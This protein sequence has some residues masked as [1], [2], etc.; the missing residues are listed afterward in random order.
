MID[1]YTQHTNADWTYYPERE[2]SMY[3]RNV[4]CQLPLYK[5]PNSESHST[6]LTYISYDRRTEGHKLILKCKT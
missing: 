4:C 3:L 5:A 2:G 1:E 6:T